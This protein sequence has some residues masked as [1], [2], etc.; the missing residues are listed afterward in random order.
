MELEGL[1]IG[2][3]SFFIVVGDCDKSFN[4]SS[5]E[6]SSS[7][8]EGELKG[9]DNFDISEL[10]FFETGI[11]E[12]NRLL[13]AIFLVSFGKFLFVLYELLSAINLRFG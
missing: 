10:S 3:T 5:K 13:S 1:Y 7:F 11:E 9:D 2:T 4:K 6:V 8:A 12:V